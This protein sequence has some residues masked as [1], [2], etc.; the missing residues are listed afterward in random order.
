MELANTLCDEI[1]YVEAVMVKVPVFKG[2]CT[3]IAV[4]YTHLAQDSDLSLAAD[5]SQDNDR[6]GYDE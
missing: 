2:S 4:S 5:M 6:L 1:F 3:A